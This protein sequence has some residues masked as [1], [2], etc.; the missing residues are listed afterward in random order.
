M[1]W[2][3]A[4]TPEGKSAIVKAIITTMSRFRYEVGRLWR[5]WLDRRSDKACT[6]WERFNRLLKRYP[7]PSPSGMGSCLAQRT[8]DLTSR[9]PYWARP[10]L[11]ETWAGDRPGPPG[12]SALQ[13][14]RRPSKLLLEL[15]K[16]MGIEPVTS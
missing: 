6:T 15:V 8:R 9:M 10:D 12:K 1:R 2:S 5:K 7:L 14:I 16:L 11:W 4:G 13:Q 3:L